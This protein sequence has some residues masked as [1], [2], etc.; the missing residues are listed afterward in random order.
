M[1]LS[2]ALRRPNAAFTLIELLVVIAIIGV[3]IALL[4]PAVQK[5]RAAA[6]TVKC[7]NNLK[8]L[9]LAVHNYENANGT[10]PAGSIT[11]T[12]PGLTQEKTVDTWTITLL[13]Y[14]EQNPLFALWTAGTPNDDP[15]PNMTA[16]RTASVS[17][18]VC[19][20]DPNLFVPA[21]PAS[22]RADDSGTAGGMVWM[23]GSYRCVSGAYGTN[24]PNGCNWDDW[25]YCTTMASWNAG[26]RGAMH[27]WHQDTGYDYSNPPQLRPPGGAPERIAN[28][29]D[30]TSN[31]LLIGEY[32]TRTNLGHRTFWAYGYTSY[33]QSSVIQGESATLLAD[34]D[35]CN[36]IVGTFGNSNECKRGWGSFHPGGI[37]N[38]AMC[39][40]SVRSIPTSIDMT[41][42]L[43]ALATIAGGEVVGNADQ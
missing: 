33:N 3:L 10:F 16:L 8:Q 20:A 22:G 38:F 30:C 14:L 34:Y 25:F 29:T 27:A 11:Y 9:A 7:K 32:A 36:M 18:Y 26:W 41:T 28:I 5:V 12:P 6:A 37:L 24:A 2:H 13:P 23:P 15:G 39:D 40:G 42:V 19:P 21:T 4:L 17:T 1:R 35:L 43:P 31:T